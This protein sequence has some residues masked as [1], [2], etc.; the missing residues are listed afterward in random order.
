MKYKLNV[1]TPVCYTSCTFNENLHEHISHEMA[2][3]VG[4]AS[5]TS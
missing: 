3:D 2:D 1:T 5:D 4:R